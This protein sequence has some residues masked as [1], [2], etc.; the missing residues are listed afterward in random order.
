MAIQ[1]DE[2]FTGFVASD[3]QLSQTEKGDARL[4]MKVGRE[5]YRKEPD[6]SFTQLET[7]FHN[8]VA[9][10]AT[11]EHGSEHLRKGDKFIASGYVR[12]YTYA[13]TNGQNVEGEEFVARH[14]GHDMARTRYEVDR[15]PRRAGVDQAAAQPETV[16]FSGPDQRRPASTS[17]IGM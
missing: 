2:S 3:P 12:E 13:D 1:T 4:Y 17:A 10:R 14:L 8:L 11:A 7:T 16:A 9:F 15:T 5:H 6:G